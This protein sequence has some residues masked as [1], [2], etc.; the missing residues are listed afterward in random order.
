MLGKKSMQKEI[1]SLKEDI[2]KLHSKCDRFIDMMA[3]LTAEVSGY[4]TELT[5]ATE[6]LYKNKNGLYDRRALHKK[7]SLVNEEEGDE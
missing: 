5:G 3:K 4:K 6:D 1:D 7:T 2:E